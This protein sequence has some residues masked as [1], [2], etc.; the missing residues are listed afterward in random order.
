MPGGGDEV[1]LEFSDLFPVEIYLT[2]NKSLLLG[3]ALQT[4]RPTLARTLAA[5]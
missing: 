3:L 1:T 4:E 2:T 5:A